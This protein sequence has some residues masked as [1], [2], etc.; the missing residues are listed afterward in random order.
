MDLLAAFR[1]FVVV[2]VIAIA[3]MSV[4]MTMM[5]AVAER[6]REVGMLRSLGFL[7]RHVVAL[8]LLEASLLALASCGVGAI[9]AL[10]LIAA[11]NRS[12]ISY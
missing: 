12:G 1:S 6:T 10:A 9:A 3:A 2:I 7:R 5:R 4:S 11:C 8:F